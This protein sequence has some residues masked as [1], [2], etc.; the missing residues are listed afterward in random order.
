ME[1]IIAF[2]TSLN[3]ERQMSDE[4]KGATSGQVYEQISFRSA[5]ESDID[6]LYS[7][8][9]ATMKKYVD[10]T[11]GWNDASQESVFRKNYVSAEIQVIAFSEKDMGMLVLE[12]RVEE[13]F[14]RAIEIHPEYQGKGIGTV[15]IKEIIADSIQ[16]MK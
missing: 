6:F 13:V 10:K 11:W 15:I 14:L 16:K 3:S 1:V 7:L 9:V 5:T 2:D 4:I 8:H 12:E